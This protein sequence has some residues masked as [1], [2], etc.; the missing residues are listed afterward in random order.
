MIA[1]LCGHCNVEKIG[2]ATLKIDSYTIIN[3][4]LNG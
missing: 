4:L 2:M 3:Y 1:H